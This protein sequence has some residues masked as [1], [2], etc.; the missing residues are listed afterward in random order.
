MARP[1]IG[2][3]VE[4]DTGQGLAYAHYTHQHP[5]YGALLRVFA[6][7]KPTRPA[8]LSAVVNGEPTFS[9]FFPL[10]AALHRNLVSIAGHVPLSERAKKF[11]V[12]RAGVVDPK[13]GKVA[14]WW[15]WDG[16]TERRVGPLTDEMRTFPIRGTWNDTILIERI[17]S[18]WTPEND[19]T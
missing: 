6:N 15:L 1:K 4:I 14:D 19:P 16:V 11:P 10:S 7:R 13:T 18:G 9:A 17:L 8:D 2:D 5:M 12:F 3:I